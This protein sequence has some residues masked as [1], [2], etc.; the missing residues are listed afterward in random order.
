MTEPGFLQ[1][2]SAPNQRRN[3]LDRTYDYIVVGAGSAGCV[4]AARLSESGKYSV[5]LLEAGGEDSSFWIHT[6]L[7]FPRLFSDPKVNW[8][9]ESEPLPEL[10]GRTS[11]TPRGKV[12]GGTS[13]I[14]GMIYMRGHA[15]DYDEWRDMGCAG[16]GYKDVLPYFRKAEDQAR[17]PDDFHGVG[18]PLKVSDQDEKH[19]IADAYIAAAVES[20]IP[21]NKDFNGA[22]QDGIGYYQTNSFKGK[23]WS[24]SRA[25]LDP[26]RGRKNLTVAT[27]AHATKVVL[28]GR[29]AVGVEYLAPGGKSTARAR[30]EVIVAGG[31]FG[32][33]QLLMLSGI[34][35]ASHLQEMG[36]PVVQ[37]SPAT[38]S[39]LQDH[40]FIQLMFRCPEPITLN[41]LARSWPMKL[42]AGA[43]YLLTGKGPLATNGILAGAFVRSDP[44][45][46]RPDLQLNMNSWSVAQRTKSGAI[47]HEFPGFTI[48]PVHL[49]PEGRGEVTLKSRDPLAA[50][51]IRF[52]FL[53]TDYDVRAMTSGIRMIRELSRRGPLK[54]FVTQ[55]IQPGPDVESDSDMESFLRRLGYANLHPVG[56]CRMG[57]QPDAVV[58]SALRVNGVQ[59]LRVVD[60]SIMPRIVAGNTHG[61]VVMIAE[62]A[63]DMILKDASDGR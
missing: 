43:R 1:S 49:K 31:V 62:K 41:E 39:N 30:R 50:P 56:T 45:L 63:S 46:A 28:Q 40:F 35:P 19:P 18:G 23:R 48:S 34:G 37:D 22:V 36:I 16:W 2:F 58:D 11:Y 55:E 29:R 13:S 5:L 54:R 61:P 8:M 32:S 10:N 44:A 57:S 51:S 47:P 20:G 9:F 7:G 24:A 25:Y 17:G 38:G 42:Q 4:L 52:S 33:P 3:E 59:G 60:A 14:N 53:S 27:R 12:L 26:A 21:A 15:A 6:P